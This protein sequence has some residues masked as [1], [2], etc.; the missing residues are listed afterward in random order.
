[1]NCENC[2][3]LYWKENRCCLASVSLDWAGMCE[4]C[5]Y[6]D[7][8]ESLLKKARSDILEKQESDVFSDM[9]K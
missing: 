9:K 4:M 8:S 2:F 3:C 6:V 5:I 7:I 1:M